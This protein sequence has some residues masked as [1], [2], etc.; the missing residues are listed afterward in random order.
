MHIHT[1][2]TIIVQILRVLYNYTSPA[3]PVSQTQIV[4]FLNES[5]ISCSRKTVGRSLKDLADLGV[6]IRRVRARNGGYYYDGEHD[7]FFVRKTPDVK[8]GEQDE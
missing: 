4:N 1:K 2:K 8:K 6:P 5:G 7:T 3:F